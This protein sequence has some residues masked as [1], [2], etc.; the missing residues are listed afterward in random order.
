MLMRLYIICICF[1]FLLYLA[2]AEAQNIPFLDVE[3]LQ[4]LHDEYVMNNT[5]LMLNVVLSNDGVHQ[6]ISFYKNLVSNLVLFI[7]DC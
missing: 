6:T 5:T 4:R 1:C 3:K 2:L 7:A